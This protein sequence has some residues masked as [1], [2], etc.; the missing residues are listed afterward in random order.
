[1]H[2]DLLPPARP[3]SLDAVADGCAFPAGGRAGAADAE[4]ELPRDP[5]AGPV[6]AKARLRH[7]FD[8]ARGRFRRF[9]RELSHF[10]SRRIYPWVPGLHYPYD[11]QLERNLTV[12]EARIEI[13]ALPRAFDGLRVLLVTDIHAG[14]FFSPRVLERCL[15]RLVRL[16]PDLILLGGDLVLSRIEEFV[17]HRCAFVRLRAPLGVFAVLGNHDHYTRHP[18][19]MRRHLQETGIG[20]LHNR[21]V[22]LRRGDATL[23]LAGIDDL[24]SGSPDLDAALADGRGPALLLSH[25]PDVLFDAARRK[26]ALVLSGHTHGGQIRAPKLP[27]LV[28]QSR[29]RLDQGRFRTGGTELVVS[30]GFGAVGLPLRLGCSPE[31]VLLTLS[32]NVPGV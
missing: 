24:V 7:L 4:L 10:L 23:R 6:A 8:P 27:V 32:S 3:V 5:L 2:R 12:S 29:Y 28:R 30:R 13:D 16:R 25:N 18:D 14:P 22:E 21:S 31:A 9:E 11:W 17:S 20:V 26:V 19:R 1:M 15:A